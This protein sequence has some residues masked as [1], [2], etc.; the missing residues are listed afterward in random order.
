VTDTPSAGWREVYRWCGVSTVAARGRAW[1]GSI[2]GGDI[3]AQ[4]VK[5]D[6]G[7]EAPEP[8]ADIER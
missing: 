1:P 5:D 7:E 6:P 8:S 3:G 2:P 4:V